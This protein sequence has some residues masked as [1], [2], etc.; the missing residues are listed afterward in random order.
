MLDV[1]G[2]GPSGAVVDARPRGDSIAAGL[3]SPRRVVVVEAASAEPGEA[4]EQIEV[5]YDD[6]PKSKKISAKAS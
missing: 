6:K 5:E 2:D 3:E 1:P 4:A